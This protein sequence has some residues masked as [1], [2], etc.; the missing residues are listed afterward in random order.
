MPA[1]L[2]LPV[3]APTE[4]A[5]K[6]AETGFMRFS[7]NCH[8]RKQWVESDKISIYLVNVN[9]SKIVAVKRTIRK[10]SNMVAVHIKG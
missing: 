8:D 7:R 1:F 4:E 9:F 10:F 2:R 5:D 6:N 3:C